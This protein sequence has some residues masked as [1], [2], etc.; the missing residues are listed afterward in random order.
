MQ[1]NEEKTILGKVVPEEAIESR[2]EL[3]KINSTLAAFTRQKAF[4]LDKNQRFDTSIP[5]YG[6][7]NSRA[8]VQ[9]FWTK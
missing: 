3:A 5:Q 9:T 2:W 4:P 7:P 6:S 1:Q 8:N